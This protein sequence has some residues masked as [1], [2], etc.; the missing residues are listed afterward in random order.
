[1]KN[2]TI[3]L[4]ETTLAWA[5]IEAAKRN[6][7][8]SRMVGEMLTAKMRDEDEYSQAHQG[9]LD[10]QRLWR[11]DGAAYPTREQTNER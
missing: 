7:S 3:T 10:K 1:M 4:H 5:R 6:S 11:S 9:W 2:L 8:V